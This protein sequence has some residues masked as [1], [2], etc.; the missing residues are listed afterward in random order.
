M[1]FV[2]ECLSEL[3]TSFDVKHTVR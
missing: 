1:N 2:A 3:I